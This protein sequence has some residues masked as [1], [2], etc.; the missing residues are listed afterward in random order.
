[1]TSWMVAWLWQGCLLTIAVSAGFRLFWKMDASTRYVIWW[2]TFAALAWLGWTL[3]PHAV[4]NRAVSALSAAPAAPAA[5]GASAV[6]EIAPLPHSLI[7]SLLALWMAGTA[8]KLV[9]VLRGLRGLYRLKQSCCPVSPAIESRLPLWQDMKN[10]GRTAQLMTCR[11]LPNAAVLGLNTPYVVFPPQL[12]EVVSACELDQILLHEYG[13]VQRRDDWARLLQ[14]V[15]EAVLW[16]HP[17][18][19]WIG[20]ALNLEREVACDD[21][22]VAITGGARAYAG[23]LSRIAH[24]SRGSDGPVLVQALF[25]RTPDVLRRVE[26]LLTPRRHVTRA[27]SL[28]AAAFAI[29][30][31]AVSVA[32]LRALPLV[33][34]AQPTGV[35]PQVAAIAPRLSASE[36]SAPEPVA[37]LDPVAPVVSLRRVPAAPQ[38]ATSNVPAPLRSE[39]VVAHTPHV[40][41]VSI[42]ESRP[43]YVAH[44]DD[45]AHA[46]L[47]PQVASQ[48][49]RVEDARNPW[50]ITGMTIGTVARKASVT[51]AGGVTKASVSIA[52]SF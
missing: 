30:T 13:H 51:V 44:P 10:H 47:P 46:V 7:T 48:Q 45:K 24:A 49:A 18:A 11:A 4:T 28:V 26:R 38:I 27:P 36:R 9:G 1:M 33:T 32:Q 42:T 31:V 34:D 3:W 52:K 37:S 6:F 17:A 20:R 43:F 29:G 14:T 25:G 12:L 5:P 40:E 16:I 21:W 2:G 41:I 22:V 23:C 35:L 15:L 50:Q 8:V 39:L 19:R